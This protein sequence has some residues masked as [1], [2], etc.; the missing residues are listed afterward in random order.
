MI[1]R[2]TIHK[3][4]CRNTYYHIVHLV[5]YC[6]IV[7]K[8]RFCDDFSNETF[9]HLC[10]GWLIYTVHSQ[11]KVAIALCLFR[12][13]SIELHCEIAFGLH[14]QNGLLPCRN[15]VARQ[16]FRSNFLKLRAERVQHGLHTASYVWVEAWLSMGMVWILAVRPFPAT[17]R[18]FT[19]GH[20][21][22]STARWAHI[23]VC[24]KRNTAACG[25]CMG[26]LCPTMCGHKRFGFFLL[27]RGRLL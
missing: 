27:P 5:G 23:P 20:V 17:A 26:G 8:N 11:N 18:I 6:K 14:L 9:T 1:I 12:D 10:K 4:M 21:L 7:L 24:V 19:E 2:S 25:R 15:R 16:R 13:F 3:S 22:Q